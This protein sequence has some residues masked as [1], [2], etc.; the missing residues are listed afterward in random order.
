LKFADELRDLYFTTQT[1]D[2]EAL[3]RNIEGQL[4]QAALE[5]K[6]S[7]AVAITDAS[8]EAVQQALSWLKS[9]GLTATADSK[10]HR[11]GSLSIQHHLSAHDRYLHISF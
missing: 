4:R 1:N 3:R 5:G 8:D 11:V 7:L 6:R 2:F 9:Q 10:R